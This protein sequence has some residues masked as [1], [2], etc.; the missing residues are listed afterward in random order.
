MKEG[1]TPLAANAEDEE[2]IA[3]KELKQ[4]DYK[5]LFMIHQYVDADNFE[6]V[7]D[8]ESAKEVWKILEKTFGGA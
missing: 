4:K 8:V 3:Y 7:S 5:A 2:N 1:V 6:K